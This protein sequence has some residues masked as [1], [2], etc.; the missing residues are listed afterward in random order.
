MF[1]YL[2]AKNRLSAIP[3]DAGGYPDPVYGLIIE[4]FAGSAGYAQ[5]WRQGH[6]VV[7]ID[8]DPSVIRLWHDLRG[9]TAAEILALPTPEAG[10]YCEKGSLLDALVK[11]CAHSNGPAHMTGPLKVPKRVVGI[12]PG[13]MKRMADRVDDV[14][15]WDIK[16]G[17]YTDAPDVE[18]TWFIDPPYVPSR[19]TKTRTKSPRGQGYLH[20]NSGIDYDELVDWCL[21]RRG[22]II[23]ADHGETWI[24][25]LA[26]RAQRRGYR[27]HEGKPVTVRALRAQYD[28]QGLPN[29]ESCLELMKITVDQ[30][31]LCE[32][33]PGK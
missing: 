29:R 16:V 19:T 24:G 32:I 28:S 10:T 11:V 4:P 3:F 7:L 31:I 5:R 25:D 18:A 9:L 17:D 33:T 6:Q 15:D 30:P 8:K 26:D 27:D 23:A 21:S 14:R 20:S 12:W 22:Q 1:Y 2:G 13:M